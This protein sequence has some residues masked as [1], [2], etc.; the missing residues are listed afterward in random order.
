LKGYWQLNNK[1]YSKESDLLRLRLETGERFKQF[2]IKVDKTQN[3]VATKLGKSNS[4][5]SSV[6]N[7]EHNL[8][9]PDLLLLCEYYG[10]SPSYFLDQESSVFGSNSIGNLDPTELTQL[11]FNKMNSILPVQVPIYMQSEYIYGEDIKPFDYVF[12]S[13]QRIATR[14]IIGVQAQTNN[15]VQNPYQSI[16]AN[17]RVIFQINTPMRVGVGAIWSF[18]RKGFENTNGLSIVEIKRKK[19]QWFYYNSGCPEDMPL[20]ESQ[21]IGMAIHKNS[22]T[23]FE[24]INPL[25]QGFE[26]KDH[27][28]KLDSE[29]KAKITKEDNWIKENLRIFK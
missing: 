24:N 16:F 11:F 18:Q 19:N 6:E 8:L 3:E 28:L 9:I 14:E 27:T 7:G 29:I 17:D 23:G 13:R 22:T 20:Q 4:W 21:Y 26:P 1:R 15:M 25:W 2:R 5:L 10:V 12:W